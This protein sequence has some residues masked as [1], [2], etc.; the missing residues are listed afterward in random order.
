MQVTNLPI[1]QLSHAL[2]F[3]FNL[4]LHVVN[5]TSPEALIL[6]DF[7]LVLHRLNDIQEDFGFVFLLLVTNNALHGSHQ[8]QFVLQ[9]VSRFLLHHS[10]ERV[11]HDRDEHIE[12]RNLRDECCEDEQN[13]Q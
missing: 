5:F 1:D 4:V 12:E 2:K 9:G 10:V 7:I 13:P 3:D 11:P 6:V 8:H